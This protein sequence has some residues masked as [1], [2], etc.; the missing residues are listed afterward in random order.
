M[1]HPILHQAAQNWATRY[2]KAARYVAELERRG[3]HTAIFSSVLATEV[4][5]V[6]DIPM[7][8]G[9]DDLDLQVYWV[10][11]PAAASLLPGAYVERQKNV[12]F[13][14]GDGLTM[15]MTVDEAKGEVD[16]M[17]I[18]LLRP[19]TPM[20]G[21]GH[22]YSRLF[23]N[24][25]VEARFLV[26]TVAGV[27]PFSH[28]LETIALYGMIQRTGDDKHDLERT[29]AI[30]QA[31]TPDDEYVPFRSAELGMDRRVWNFI[32]RAAAGAPAPARMPGGLL[33]PPATPRHSL[34]EKAL[35]IPARA[36]YYKGKQY[37]A[38]SAEANV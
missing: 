30:L 33:V 3:I 11:F 32:H 34:F 10:D 29:G 18:H 19:L 5:R 22:T 25:A 4:A 36:F 17:P 12:S 14:A 7:T 16:G 20:S 9:S 23:T 26:E 28:P 8:R 21:G 6:L 38:G 27:I 37:K 24:R 1:I 13:T 35:A 31:Y 15:R 2:P